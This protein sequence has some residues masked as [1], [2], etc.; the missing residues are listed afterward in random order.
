[1][2]ALSPKSEPALTDEIDS[3]FAI[4][5]I[6]HYLKGKSWRQLAVFLHILIISICGWYFLKQGL[7]INIIL[8][9][10]I[11]LVFLFIIFKRK[12]KSLVRL[13]SLIDMTGLVEIT[14]EERAFDSNLQALKA[15]IISAEDIHVKTQL[16]GGDEKGHTW[17]KQD[18]ALDEMLSRRDAV[19]HG[20]VFDGLEGELTE[21]EKMVEM[22]NQ[23]YA[24]MAERR[25]QDAEKEDGDLQEYGVEK[26]AELVQTDYFEKHAQDGVF[27]M[28]AKHD[29][30]DSEPNMGTSAEPE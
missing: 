28:T 30:E 5:A 20:G 27:A 2:T 3:D 22:A 29:G 13:F 10:I 9:C 14:E 6:D 17:G 25:W 16:R 19:E 26:L 24:D 12:K 23:R 21:G 4:D 8:I 1:M 11:N 7:S 15:R 18:A